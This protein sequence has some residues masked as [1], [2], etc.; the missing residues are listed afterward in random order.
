MRSFLFTV[1]V[2]I[3]LVA[4]VTGDNADDMDMPVGEITAAS[5]DDL[6]DRDVSD[7]DAQVRSDRERPAPST[8]Q[9]IE[10]GASVKQQTA[11]VDG[12]QP[13]IDAALT[14]RPVRDER[15]VPATGGQLEQDTSDVPSTGG[16]LEQDGALP[17]I[18]EDTELET[19]TDEELMQ[20]EQEGR[21]LP[22][23]DA[24]LR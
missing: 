15:E 13:E 14:K 7:E 1:L 18:V 4:C 16:Q 19:L 5:Q 17:R 2:S 22:A 6:V 10:Q 9:T 3:N 23:K 20:L 21:I 12:S 8:A 24:S 11:T